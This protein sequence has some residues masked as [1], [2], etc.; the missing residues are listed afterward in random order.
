MSSLLVS[1]LT[2][3]FVF[4]ALALSAQPALSSIGMTTGVGILFALA[5]S[6]AVSVLA[7]RTR[8]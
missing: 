8:T 2:T 3:L 5:L 4:G 1:C 7:R 6:P